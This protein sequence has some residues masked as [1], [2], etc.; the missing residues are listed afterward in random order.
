MPTSFYVGA[1]EELVEQE[2]LS[3]ADF[4]R[5][6]RLARIVANRLGVSI[7]AVYEMVGA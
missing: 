7:G 2:F 4:H 5:M 1:L 3:L 6:G